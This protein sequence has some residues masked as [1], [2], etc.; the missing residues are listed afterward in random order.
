[1]GLNI[2]I[3]IIIGLLG[4]WYSSQG[5]LSGLLHLVCVICAASLAF[6]W[7]EP[8]VVDN[9]LNTSWWSGLMPGFML[10][11]IFV[12][13]LAILRMA[14]DKLAFGNTRIPRAIDVAGGAIMGA[15]SGVLTA[16]VLLLGN[17]FVDQTTAILG[18]QG[19][20]AGDN[21]TIQWGDG[22]GAAKLWLPVDS[23]TVEVL[24]T[25][26]LASMHPDLSGR[27]LARWNPELDRQAWLLRDRLKHKSQ[28]QFTQMIQPPDS[29]TV[30][31]AYQ[32]EASDGSDLWVIPMSFKKN[33][34]DF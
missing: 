17:G 22:D 13:T 25:L 34:M 14:S 16:G 23:W 6:A 33:G 2:A 8:I 20:R 15:L 27:P 11:T 1:M 31:R 30:D 9:M 21:G 29:I 3:I 28:P 19:W 26:S 32:Y 10:L 24:E 5:F 4:Y 18:M 12:I 7:W